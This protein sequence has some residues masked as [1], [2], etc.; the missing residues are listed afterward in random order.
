MS[1]SK[2]QVAVVGCGYWGK[3][4][5]RNFYE[6][7]ALRMV[8]D[9]RRE[10][11]DEQARYQAAAVTTIGEVLSNPEVDAVVIAAPAAQHY[12]LARRTLSAG[13]DVY[14]EKPLALHAE[15]GRKLT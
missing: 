4:L 3:N 6:L 1:Q 12:D 5:V 15:E 13:K 9:P 10:A 8:C 2:T 14:I 11:L 7:G